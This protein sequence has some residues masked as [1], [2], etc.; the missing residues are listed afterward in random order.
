MNGPPLVVYGS[1]R[2]WSPERFRST[3]QGYFLPASAVGMFAY[4]RAGLWVPQ[5]THYYLVCLAP[6]L[7]GTLIGRAVHQRMESSLF[8]T[9][10]HVGLLSVGVLLLIQAAS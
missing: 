9:C 7:A 1:L 3:L 6:I 8:R 4:W 2:R 10:V 5:V